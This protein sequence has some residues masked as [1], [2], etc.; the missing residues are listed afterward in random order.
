[1]KKA[2]ISSGSKQYIVSEGDELNVDKLDNTKKQDL[3]ALLVINED[4]TL[5]GKPKVSGVKVTIEVIEPE[6]LGEKVLA[7]R[8]KAKKRVRKVRG[9]RQRYSKIKVSK[10]SL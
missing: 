8:Y 9:H 10:I 6:I 5:V 7:I 4:K 3:E 2:V 1:M